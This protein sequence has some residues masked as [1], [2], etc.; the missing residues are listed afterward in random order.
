MAQVAGLIMDKRGQSSRDKASFAG[1]DKVRFR[2]PVFAGDTLVLRVTLVKYYQHFK[3]AKM[4]G[5][6]Y[7]DGKVVCEGHFS[8]YTGAA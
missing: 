6:A 7:V 3:I 4:E 8:I 5:K 1:T 2:K